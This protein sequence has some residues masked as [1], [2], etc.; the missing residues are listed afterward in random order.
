MKLPCLAFLTV[1]LV[2]PG[3]RCSATPVSP[4]ADSP[5]TAP[6]PIPQEVTLTGLLYRRVAMGGETTGW[7]LRQD[8]KSSIELLLPIT[9]FD[10]VTEGMAVALTGTYV[11]R[12]Y[13]ERGEVRMFAVRVLSEVEFSD[14]GRIRGR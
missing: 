2:L 8:Q 3:T 12:T 13:P 11:T 7:V 10:R 6:S 14:F 1:L 4:V 5:K 9:A